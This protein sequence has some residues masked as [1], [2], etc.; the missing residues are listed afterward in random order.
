MQSRRDTQGHLDEDGSNASYDEL[1]QINSTRP[2]QT[3]SWLPSGHEIRDQILL[4]LRHSVILPSF[5]LSLLHFTVLSFAGHLVAYLM[6]IGYN[7][8]YIGILRTVSVLVE[9]ST[10]CIAPMAMRRVGPI[11]VGL[12]SITWQSLWISFGVSIF[13][14]SD[15]G[16][17]TTSG[18]LLGVIA[19]RLGLWGFDLAVQNLIQVVSNSLDTFKCTGG[20]ERDDHLQEVEAGA[21][22]S[23]SSAEVSLQNLFELGSYATTVGFSRPNQ[24]RYPALMSAV[25]VQVAAMLFALFVRQRRGHLLHV[26]NCVKKQKRQ[27]TDWE[28]EGQDRR[29]GGAIPLLDRA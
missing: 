20:A 6:A 7:P 2:S 19:S 11:R 29:T 3:S 16:W 27:P 14:S 26:S 17:W 13:W 23:F 22:G 4:Y 5:A 8:T 10:T 18:L 12:W 28:E 25:A 24:F 9:V 21:R 15:E 1:E